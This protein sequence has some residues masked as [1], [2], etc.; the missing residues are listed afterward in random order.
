MHINGLNIP[1]LAAI[2]DRSNIVTEIHKFV[3]EKCI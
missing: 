1:Y 2:G 3:T